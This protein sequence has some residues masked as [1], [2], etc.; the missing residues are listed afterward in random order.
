MARRQNLTKR[1]AHVLDFVRN[2]ISENNL[3]PTLGEIGDGLGVNRVTVFEHVRALEQ[4]GWIRTE[5]HQSR[6]IE[7]VSDETASPGVPIYGRIAAGEPIDV[8]PEAERD[9]FNPAELF[10][11]D[12]DLYMLEVH[13]ESMIEDQIRDGD[14]VIVES[15]QTAQPGETVVALV[16]GREATLKRYYPMGRETRLEPRNSTMEPIILPTQD[17]TVQGVVVGVLRQY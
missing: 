12:K 13:G 11:D 14:H 6:S 17:V 1:Q 15:R 8:V 4:K 16:R 5:R 10:R 3:S 7:L 9:T 2:Y